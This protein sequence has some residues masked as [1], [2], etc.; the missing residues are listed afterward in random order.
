MQYNMPGFNQSAQGFSNEADDPY[1]RFISGFNSPQTQK[2][3][4]AMRRVGRTAQPVAGY[5]AKKNAQMGKADYS[6]SNLQSRTPTDGDNGSNAPQS[7]RRQPMPAPDPYEGS[8][9]QLADKQFNQSG[10]TSGPAGNMTYK[11]GPFKGMT[12]PEAFQSVQDQKVNRE[13][14]LAAANT[15]LSRVDESGNP[16]RPKFGYS[17]YGQPQDLDPNRVNPYRDF[18]T[19]ASG[20]K[21]SSSLGTDD[22]QLRNEAERREREDYYRFFDQQDAMKAGQ[23]GKDAV[24]AKKQEQAAKKADRDRK[25]TMQ[26]E[27]SE[28]DGMT[29]FYDRSGKQVGTT[30]MIPEQYGGGMGYAAAPGAPPAQRLDDDQYM[31]TGSGVPMKVGQARAPLPEGMSSNSA[32][33][34]DRAD[35]QTLA[36]TVEARMLEKQSRE[37]FRS[38]GGGIAKSKAPEGTFF[39]SGGNAYSTNQPTRYIPDW[40]K[41]EVGPSIFDKFF[42]D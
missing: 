39:D 21:P 37:N 31:M 3:Q 4:T 18:S 11:K 41:G 28:G 6:E 23:K 15:G 9:E 24:M 32:F 22:F 19:T 35:A 1:S 42:K 40:K 5:G 17:K 26:G 14:E 36:N 29:R 7:V 8:P 10:Y 27:V 2:T 34:K 25:I 12:M 13:P 16:I 33:G 30:Q 20:F 38:A